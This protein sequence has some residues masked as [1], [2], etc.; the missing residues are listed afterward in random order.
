MQ[1][2]KCAL[3]WGLLILGTGAM[4]LNSSVYAD[5]TTS[6]NTNNANTILPGTGSHRLPL[7]HQKSPSLVVF[8]TII[9]A[10]HL[11]RVEGKEIVYQPDV[12]VRRAK[13]R[14]Y[15]FD[16]KIF[17]ER[18]GKPGYFEKKQVTC[19]IVRQ[20]Q[21][22]HTALVGTIVTLSSSCELVGVK[23]L[24]TPAPRPAPSNLPPQPVAGT[25]TM[26]KTRLSGQVVARV[27]GKLKQSVL[28][29][30]ANRH[31]MMKLRHEAKGQ[32][33]VVV[34]QHLGE[35]RKD[36]VFWR[37]NILS[38][39]VKRASYG[40]L[41]LTNQDVLRFVPQKKSWKTLRLLMEIQEYK[42]RV[43]RPTNPYV[44]APLG[45]FQFHE[46]YGRIVSATPKP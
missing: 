32:R 36:G 12:H 13:Y 21:K 10:P 20:Q 6:N 14:V 34:L 38:R 33:V 42:K 11:F 19:R 5:T 31:E 46:F 22:S 43:H 26:P 40:T 27:G 17:E 7:A 41:F 15:V 9:G 1:L 16:R 30:P 44:S 37:Y 39:F 28:T 4:H 8:L 18:V 23:S 29:L 2:R 25:Q 35:L 24:E 45:G 3:V